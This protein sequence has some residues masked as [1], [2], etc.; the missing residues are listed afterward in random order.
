MDYSSRKH[1]S[2]HRQ[3]RPYR[4]TVLVTV[5]D[6]TSPRSVSLRPKPSTTHNLSSLLMNLNIFRI[7]V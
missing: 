4:T 2:R 6:N 3:P 7:I 1:K 5:W